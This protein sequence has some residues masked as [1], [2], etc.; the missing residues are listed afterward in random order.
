MFPGLNLPLYFSGSC[1]EGFQSEADYCYKLFTEGKSW[2]KAVK[3][4]N[5]MKAS[6]V[7]VTDKDEHSFLTQML[8]KSTILRSWIGL[9]DR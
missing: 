8:S 9:N 5:D 3:A 4:C 7:S 1:P 2:V 6:L